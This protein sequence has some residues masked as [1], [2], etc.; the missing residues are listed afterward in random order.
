MK[1]IKIFTL[2]SILLLIL[3][4]TF[5]LLV[6]KNDVKPIGPEGSEVGFAEINQ[7]A[8]NT[9]KY[10]D[11]WYKISK[12][13]GMI[14]I[15]IACFYAGRG[16]RQLAKEKSFKKINKKLYI[17]GAFY[18]LLVALYLFFEKVIINYRPVLED[19]KLEASYPSSH[20]LLAICICLSSIII[21]KDFISNQKIRKIF[22]I[23]TGLVMLI[24]V[25]GRLL[26]GVHWLTDIIGGIIIS[27][28]MVSAF[29]TTV[30]RLD[31]KQ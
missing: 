27:L 13:C 24:I 25:F 3:S 26:S 28:F 19:G 15:C 9:I 17:L 10:N 8:H 6:K 7:K 1:K 4:I 16:I 14:P 2:I 22:D 5:T 20:T 21:S 30:L 18:A 31:Q 12:Y 23:I 29:Y 11:T